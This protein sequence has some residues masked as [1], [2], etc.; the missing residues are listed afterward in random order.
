MSNDIFTYSLSKTYL[1]KQK[2]TNLKISPFLTLDRPE[3]K[4]SDWCLGQ[5]CSLIFE[6]YDNLYIFISFYVFYI[7]ITIYKW[8]KQVSDTII[9]WFMTFINLLLWQ[10]WGYLGHILACYSIIIK[11]SPI[12][13]Y[14]FFLFITRPI[15]WATM[16]LHLNTN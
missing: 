14:I 2:W 4:L 3:S 12:K 15:Q 9:W 11:D 10:W 16:K 1:M 6:K 5:F 7:N 13:V 8:W